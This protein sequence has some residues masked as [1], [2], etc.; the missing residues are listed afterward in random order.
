MNLHQYIQDIVGLLAPQMCYACD[1]PLTSQEQLICLHCLSQIEQ[2]DFHLC[3]SDNELYNRLAGRVPLA[4][5]MALFYFDKA[6][7]MQRLIQALKYQDAPQLG[8]VLG[9]KY[10]EILASHPCVEGYDSLVPVP[11][12]PSRKRK[13]T[14]NQAEKIAQGLADTLGLKMRRE[15][16]IRSRKTQTQTKLSGSRRWENVSS[17]FRL[18]KSLS[19]NVLLVD[20]VIT[21]GATLEACIRALM[22][23]DEP[24][25]KIGVISLGIARAN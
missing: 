14:Y 22:Q 3:S 7:R 8:R 5:A 10:G 21:T 1:R 17:A 23:Q 18:K 12:H 15:Y 9:Q 24:P 4:D 2:T 20:D 16:L 13:R 25:Q 6:G 19:E 11:L